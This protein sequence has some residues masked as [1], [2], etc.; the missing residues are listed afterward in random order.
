MGSKPTGRNLPIKKERFK[1]KDQK[2]RHSSI[3]AQNKLLTAKATS[4][5]LSYPAALTPHH[6]PDLAMDTRTTKHPTI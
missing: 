5:S 4:L 2:Q 6:Y 3:G 1:L